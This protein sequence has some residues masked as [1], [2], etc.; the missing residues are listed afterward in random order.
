M[1]S[2]FYNHY[3]PE[4]KAIM[5]YN[6]LADAYLILNQDL[7]NE[8]RAKE[9]NLEELYTSNPKLYNTLKE[10]GFIIPRAFDEKSYY[11]N[12]LFNRR[13]TSKIYQVIINPTLDCNLGCWYCYEDHVPDSEMDDTIIKK[14]LN[15]IK[16]KYK[17]EQFSELWLSF[18]GGE[19]LL[20][21]NIVITILNQ[22]EKFTKDKKIK[23][24][25][26]FTTNATLIS[27]ELLNV[28]KRF[29]V[30]FQI[31][32]DGNEI[33]H[34]SSRCFK[35]TNKPTYKL[36]IN[37]INKIQSVLKNY[38]ISVRINYH[39][40]ALEGLYSVIDDLAFADKR[41]L[42]FSLMRIWQVNQIEIS[43]PDI[44]K[45]TN[46]AQEK[47]FIVNFLSLTPKSSVCYADCLNEVVVN[48]D[49]NVHKCTA[50]N[51]AKV[52]PDGVLMDNGVINW[53]IDRLSRRLATNISQICKDCKLL[54]S[55]PGIC[56]Q[57]ILEDGENAKCI[58]DTNLSLDD[59]IT[60]NFNRFALENK[61][62]K[63]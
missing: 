46:Y 48:Y 39:Q 28:L 52:K 53:D 49:G 32:L 59:H 44:F 33:M 26:A 42:R 14:L 1:K 24:S 21:T 6:A 41:F 54:P 30:N 47:G 56:S 15:H 61:L 11:L 40:K 43:W 29:N 18:F 22:I 57:K 10:N 55:C 3:V 8:F 25:V 37:N 16:L 9:E 51:F 20:K 23:I 7:F 62:V 34:D 4:G 13:F 2:S 17:E 50:R 63:I 19:P 27:D 38:G 45:F 60:Y 35:N 5:L 31:T 12:L 36:I 58:L